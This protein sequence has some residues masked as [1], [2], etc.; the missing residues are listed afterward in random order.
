MEY[1]SIKL[2]KAIIE[3]K[4]LSTEEYIELLIRKAKYLKR[5]KSN[6]KTIIAI[7]KQLKLDLSKFK[8]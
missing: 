7:A 2:K 3:K 1:D 8:I 5:K 4:K 6:E